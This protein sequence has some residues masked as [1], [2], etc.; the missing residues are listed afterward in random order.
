M[1][2]SSL[3]K[4]IGF[5]YVREPDAISFM[6]TLATDEFIT[7]FVDRPDAERVESNEADKGVESFDYD[8]VIRNHGDLLDL[9]KT[10]QRFVHELISLKGSRQ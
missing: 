7:V 9:Q 6:K 8:F 2:Q 5:I 3:M 10:A 1:F 4:Q